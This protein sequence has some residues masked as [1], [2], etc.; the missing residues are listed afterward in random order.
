MDIQTT[1]K[2]DKA[3]SRFLQPEMLLMRHKDLKQET[4]QT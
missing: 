4:N 2:F 3:I 1:S